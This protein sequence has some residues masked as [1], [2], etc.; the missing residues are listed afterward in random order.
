M[1]HLNQIEAD[2]WVQLHVPQQAHPHQVL[3]APARNVGNSLMTADY[4]ISP[5]LLLQF[6]IGVECRANEVQYQ[7]LARTLESATVG[8]LVVLVVL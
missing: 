5:D 8:F 1:P 4:L 7:D 6:A 3:P 2:G